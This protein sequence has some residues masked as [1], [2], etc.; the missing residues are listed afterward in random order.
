M[1]EKD[2]T[3]DA[4]HRGDGCLR[5]SEFV[6]RGPY[7]VAKKQIILKPCS[8]YKSQGKSHDSSMPLI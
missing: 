1:G 3:A 6:T 7:K 5:K 4:T 2:L 8:H